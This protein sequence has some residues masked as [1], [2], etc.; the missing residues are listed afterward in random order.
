MHDGSSN[1]E[2][3]R[4]LSQAISELDTAD[5]RR[6]F[7]DAT[8]AGDAELREELLHTLTVDAPVPAPAA[9]IEPIETGQVF[10][11]R[12]HIVRKLGE[13]GMAAVYEA[14]DAKLMERRALKIPKSKYSSRISDEARS[15]LRITHENICR[16]HEI[17]T[18]A[19]DDGPADFISMELLNGETL[20]KRARR[21]PI[22]QAEALDIARQLCRG[23]AAAHSAGILHQDFKSNNVMLTHHANGV[24]RVVITDFGLALPL[25]AAEGAPVKRIAGTPNY[26]APERWK[27]EPASTASDIYGLGVVL[28]EMLAGRLP[29]PPG[30]DWSQRLNSAPEPPSRSPRRPD[31]RWD[32]IVLG[33]L[34]PDPAKRA[35]SAAA[36]LAA[37]ERAFGGLM[38]R[39][40]LVAAVA[41]IAAATPI[42]VFRDSIWPP[43]LVRLAIL[44]FDGADAGSEIGRS[45]KGALYDISRRLE[46]LGAAS[47]RLVVVPLEESWHSE[48]ASPAVAASR[49]GATHVLSGAVIPRGDRFSVR[50][51]VT[52]TRTGEILREFTGDYLPSD[53]SILPDALAGVVTSAFH[54]NKAPPSK[55]NAAA[56]P[57]YLR[58]LAAVGKIPPDFDGAASAFEEAAKRDA[59]SAT[60]YG[61]LG[62]AYLREYQNISD[63]KLLDAAKAAAQR[64]QSLQPDSPSVVLV[65]GSIEESEGRPERAIELFQR[66]AKLEPANPEGWRRS[67]LALQRIGRDAD[68][69]ADL[70]RAV[71]LAPDYY[72]PHQSLGYA[73]FSSG[74][75]AEAVEEFRTVT[76]LAPGSAEA[77]AS[78]GGM[79]LI[80]ERDVDA[81]NELRKA[82]RLHESSSVLNNLAVVLAYEHRDAE[83]VDALQRALRRNPDDP[84]T[85]LNLALALRRL[86]K[87]RDAREQF[88]HAAALSR[89]EL[90]RD[91]RNAA[92]RAR[93]SYALVRVGEPAIAA[94]EAF[95]AARLAPREHFVV[96][97][98]VMTMEAL[99]RRDDALNLLA[100]ASYQRLKDLRRQPDLAGLA[101]DPRFVAL[102]RDSSE[103]KTDESTNSSKPRIN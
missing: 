47:Q 99:D 102:L 17:H 1:G 78:L 22:P 21:E 42:V 88:E 24:L 53:I 52:D 44:P 46:S 27:G 50:A 70:R 57:A 26:I 61:N 3:F 14:L 25:R 63:P 31:R 79:L 87:E 51:A 74:R 71:Q 40:L 11:D 48:I 8:C 45:T 73:L 28:Y 89:A 16:T 15:A 68:A 20:L 84:G 76:R 86:G 37:I 64:A 69:I 58:G 29:F 93:L 18:R 103:R 13:G 6:S 7:L 49:L 82:V 92:A 95:Q 33:C 66:A 56:Y 43:P 38:R 97:W 4:M 12:F 75:Y 100:G 9:A 65:L 35:S 36:V 91:P 62:D 72:L 60:I 96:F 85:R 83:A 55:V 30:P 59:T 90:L 77:H 41:V 39:R 32:P 19:T 34:Q 67:G 10:G 80:L 98:C 94:D 2:R 23:L 81:E 54:L 101:R 5:E